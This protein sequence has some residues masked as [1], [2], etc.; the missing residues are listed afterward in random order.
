MYIRKT[1]AIAAAICST[2][3]LSGQ[4]DP[5]RAEAY[6]KE[7]KAFCE[8]DGGRLWGVSLCGPMVIA[9]AATGT[10]ATNQPAPEAA[11]PRSLGFANAITEW[12]GVQWST[13]VWQLLASFDEP[14]RGVLM[15]HELFH[16]VER[17]LGLMTPDGQNNHLDTLEGRYWQL[18]EWRALARGLG[19][20]GTERTSAVRD[21]LAF[22]L[23]RRQV[24]P[25]AAENEVLEEIREGLAHYTAIVTTASSPQDAASSAI[26]VLADYAKRESLVRDFGYASGTAYGV[27]LDAW[28]P[29]WTRQLKGPEDLG[30]RLRVAAG[31][32]VTGINSREAADQAALRYD[33]ASLRTAEEKRDADQ[34]ANV[35]ELRRRF[36][37][38]PVLVLPNAGGSFS[39]SG[40]TPIPGVGTVFP[41]VHVTAEW[42][43]LDAAQVLRPDDRSNITLP[44]PAS[45]Q[46]SM[47]EGSGWT[48]K[49]AAGW[50]V[51]AGNRPGDFQLVRNVPRQ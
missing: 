49:I 33:S 28:S 7:A 17:P 11:R 35:A 48:L 13:F 46:G 4:I 23:A 25:A 5:V 2:L 31:I 20:S 16:R 21:A 40:I 3:P 34:K 30:E 15:M 42:G 22:R 9:D 27:L 24:F 6:F 14:S 19:S 10:I 1:L 45:V 50:V 39:N 12:G 37:D 36:V 38:G 29:G 32:A 43:V 41:T 51:R 8:R 47:L 18:L 44:A 26:L